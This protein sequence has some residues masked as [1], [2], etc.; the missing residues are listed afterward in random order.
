MKS[1]TILGYTLLL[2]YIFVAFMVI[3]FL[4]REIVIFFLCRCFDA[5]KLSRSEMIRLIVYAGIATTG[6]WLSTVFANLVIHIKS[7]RGKKSSSNSSD[8]P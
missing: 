8:K 6:A 3:A 7:S 5:F 4:T 2:L 1:R